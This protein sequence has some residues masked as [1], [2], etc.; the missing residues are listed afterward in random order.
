MSEP[1]DDWPCKL[2]ESQELERHNTNIFP[3]QGIKNPSDSIGLSRKDDGGFTFPV[4]QVVMDE[5]DEETESK[6]RAFLDEKVLRCSKECPL[7]SLY[8]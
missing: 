2:D 5:D 6:I 7:I 4:G 3:S 1:E 8:S